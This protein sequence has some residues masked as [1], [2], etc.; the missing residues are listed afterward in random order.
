MKNIVILLYSSDPFTTFK[1]S[2]IMPLENLLAQGCSCIKKN[3]QELIFQISKQPAFQM[4]GF[5]D[6]D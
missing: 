2:E 5:P 4:V 6:Q 1:V 3:F